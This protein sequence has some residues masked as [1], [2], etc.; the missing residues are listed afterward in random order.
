MGKTHNSDDSL[1][2]WKPVTDKRLLKTPVLTV[3]QLTSRSPK[4]DEHDYIIIN[5]PDWV[6]VIPVIQSPPREQFIMVRQ[7]RHAE[8][9]LSVEFPGGVINRGETPEQAAL[10]ELLEETGY[11]AQ[12]LVQL[13]SFSPNPALMTNHQ[14]FF[15]AFDLTDTGARH[16]DYDEYVHVLIEDTESVYQHMR[17]GEYSHGLMACGAFLYQQYT[18][19]VHQ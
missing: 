2:V 1:L 8:N 14:H 15:L 13:S 4:G 19:T 17:N 7:W 6:T 9:R 16:L 12:K 5:T 10:R 11:H 18:R 3:E